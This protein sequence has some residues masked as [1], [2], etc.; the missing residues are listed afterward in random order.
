MSSIGWDDLGH[1]F[2]RKCLQPIKSSCD[3][4]MQTRQPDHEDMLGYTMHQLNSCTSALADA[5]EEPMEDLRRDEHI[6]GAAK[7]R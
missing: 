2:E 3:A 7:S 5:L 1:G 6:V 4:V